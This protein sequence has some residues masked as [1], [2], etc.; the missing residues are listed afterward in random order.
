MFTENL[1]TYLKEVG[2]RKKDLAAKT[3]LYPESI[4][5]WNKTDKFC[6][7]RGSLIKI[8]DALNAELARQR[9]PYR[10]SINDLLS[11]D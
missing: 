7:S 11:D 9:K 2:W 8:R 5:R 3:G 10:I 1:K 4:S 6:P